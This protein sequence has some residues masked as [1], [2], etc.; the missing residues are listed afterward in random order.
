MLIS[1]MQYVSWQIIA[2]ILDK[3]ALYEYSTSELGETIQGM[4]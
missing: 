2:G 1:I 3:K 4:G